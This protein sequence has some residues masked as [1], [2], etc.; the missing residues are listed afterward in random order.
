MSSEVSKVMEKREVF[1]EG[2]NRNC[3]VFAVAVE[4]E[5]E[6]WTCS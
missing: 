1:E 6:T 5:S 3:K 2:K 4:A